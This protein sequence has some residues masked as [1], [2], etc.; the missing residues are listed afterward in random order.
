MLLTHRTLPLVGKSPAGRSPQSRQA[1]T[2]R[3]ARA[4]FDDPAALIGHPGVATSG[5]YARFNA[6][7]D[8]A[9][10]DEFSGRPQFAPIAGN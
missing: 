7:S 3:K 1:S 6:Y 10:C 4:L 8:F 2:R 9:G 5:K